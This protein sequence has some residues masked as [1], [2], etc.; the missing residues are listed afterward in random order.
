MN[1]KKQKCPECDGKN[2]YV[3]EVTSGGLYGP[4]LLPGLAGFLRLAKFRVLVCSGCGLTRFY[5]EAAGCAKLPSVKGWWR[6]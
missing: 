1:S 4:V 6:V 2:L 5:A 3:T